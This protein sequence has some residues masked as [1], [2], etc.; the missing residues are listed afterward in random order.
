MIRLVHISTEVC[1]ILCILISINPEVT[2]LKVKLNP[3][4][5]CSCKISEGLYPTN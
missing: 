3:I 5:N 1:W 4:D 2:I